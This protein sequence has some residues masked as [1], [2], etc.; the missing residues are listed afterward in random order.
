MIRYKILFQ[1]SHKTI[2]TN[3]NLARFSEKR[4]IYKLFKNEKADIWVI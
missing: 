2:Q 3:T 1:T 4:R